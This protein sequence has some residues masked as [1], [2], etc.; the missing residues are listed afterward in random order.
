MATEVAEG[1]R[2]IASAGQTRRFIDPEEVPGAFPH[3]HIAIRPSARGEFRMRVRHAAVQDINLSH[4]VEILPRRASMSFR[5]ERAYFRFVAPHD[6]PKIRNGREDIPGSIAIGPAEYNTEDVTTGLSVSRSLSV[7]LAMMLD[8]TQRLM[9]EGNRPVVGPPAKPLQPPAPLLVRLMSLQ[10]QVLGAAPGKA[11]PAAAMSAA[12]WEVLTDILLSAE[13]DPRPMRAARE[14]AALRRATEFITANH[15][16]PVALWELCEAG[17]CSA[18]TLELVFLRSVG[19]TPNR[20][21]RRWRLW[22]ARDA[23]SAADPAETTVSE[24]A[25]AHGFWELGRF[26]GAYREIFGEAPSATLRARA[27]HRPVTGRMGLTISA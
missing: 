13:P 20:Y 14:R 24:I 21:M 9:L 22:R 25:L 6:R 2:A 4:T 23:L 8:R 16:R 7:P 18:K 1:E 11:V 5:P 17:G 19:E 10:R 12:I 3:C 26:A 27:S 15:D